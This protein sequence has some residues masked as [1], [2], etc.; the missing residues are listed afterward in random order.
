MVTSTVLFKIEILNIKSS[1]YQ[2]HCKH[3][4]AGEENLSTFFI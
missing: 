3:K 1:E 2:Y 4:I